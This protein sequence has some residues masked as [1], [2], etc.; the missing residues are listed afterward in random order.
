MGIKDD[1]KIEIPF[2]KIGDNLELYGKNPVR[3]EKKLTQPPNR[4]NFDSLIKDLDDLKNRTCPSTLG[5]LCS[6]ITSKSYVEMRG[7]V[8]HPTI[9]LGKEIIIF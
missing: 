7:H 2:L 6:K 8:F 3:L 4:Y 9:F 5:E 1:S